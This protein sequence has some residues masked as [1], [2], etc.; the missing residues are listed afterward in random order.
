MIPKGRGALKSADLPSR[1][2]WTLPRSEVVFCAGKD[3]PA[4]RRAIKGGN[5]EAWQSWDLHRVTLQWAPRGPL[6]CPQFS[7][8]ALCELVV[9]APSVNAHKLRSLRLESKHTYISRYSATHLCSAKTALKA[10]T[11]PLGNL[12]RPSAL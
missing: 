6:L 7:P 8:R 5:P 12:S 10:S 4:H 1:F 9:F 11:N 2:S 3:R